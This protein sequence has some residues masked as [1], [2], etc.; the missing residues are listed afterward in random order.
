MFRGMF[1]LDTPKILGSLF[2]STLKTSKHPV[3]DPCK[4]FFPPPMYP[5]KNKVI[6]PYE[7]HMK[8][9]TTHWFPQKIGPAINAY[10]SKGGL[11]GGRLTSH[12]C[13]YTK[14]VE[15]GTAPPSPCSQASSHTLS[16]L[17][18]CVCVCVDIH[19]QNLSKCIFACIYIYTLH[20][21]IL[22]FIYTCTTT[23][24]V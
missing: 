1:L 15:S 19:V 16:G 24:L 13:R 8:T 12:Q 22:V 21:C 11:V 10:E 17:I 4:S 18:V 23:I 6:R 20:M 2:I 5:P 3:L 7:G 14:A 9:Q